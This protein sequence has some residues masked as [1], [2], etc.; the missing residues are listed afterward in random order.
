MIDNALNNT[1]I[2]LTKF[3]KK[4]IELIETVWEIIYIYQ[5]IWNFIGKYLY[6]AMKFLTVW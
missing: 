6:L 1:N 3:Y 5:T 4:P 2:F